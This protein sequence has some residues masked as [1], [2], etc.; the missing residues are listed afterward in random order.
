MKDEDGEWWDAEVVKRHGDQLAY[1][2]KYTGSGQWQG[3]TESRIAESR[4][5]IRV[6]LCG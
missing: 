3:S 2:V 6:R 1:E 5:K 4:L